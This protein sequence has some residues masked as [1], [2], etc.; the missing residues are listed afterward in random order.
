MPADIKNDEPYI[1]T[2]SGGPVWEWFELTYS[3]YLVLPR[4]ALCS[5]PL[6]WQEKFVALLREAESMLPDEAQGQEYMVRARK[7][8]RFVSDGMSDY[9]HHAPLELKKP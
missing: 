2:Y 8:G 5:M 7:N 4:V 3:A 9:R 1:N 6:E